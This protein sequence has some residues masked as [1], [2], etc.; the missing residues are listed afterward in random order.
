MTLTEIHLAE[1]RSYLKEF[2]AF[3]KDEA[4]QAKAE[5]INELIPMMVDTIS[6]DELTSMSNQM[7]SFV[8]TVMLNRAI[9][10]IGKENDNVD[11]PTNEPLVTLVSH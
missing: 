3:S 5:T 6:D 9:K 7:W 10:A 8:T 11:Q 4:D 1:L 2:R